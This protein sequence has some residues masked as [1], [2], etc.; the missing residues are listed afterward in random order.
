MCVCVWERL[1]TFGSLRDLDVKWDFCTIYQD[2]E[3][4]IETIIPEYTC[5][6]YFGKIS[7]NAMHKDVVQITINE[8]K[9][10]N[11]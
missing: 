10:I 1:H 3:R 11:N 2:T 5:T 6:Q 9:S 8:Y 7:N 4:H